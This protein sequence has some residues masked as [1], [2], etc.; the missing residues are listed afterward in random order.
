MNGLKVTG[1]INRQTSR[2]MSKPRCG[3]SDI[4]Q[5]HTPNGNRQKRDTS[6]TFETTLNGNKWKSRR[7]TW[8]L[9]QYSNKIYW[10]DQQNI[11]DKIF[12]MWSV[13]SPLQIHHTSNTPDIDISFARWIHGDGNYNAFDGKGRM[14][15][16]AYGPGYGPLAGDIH[17]DNDE[18]WATKKNL[19][20]EHAKDFFPIAL[21]EAGH[22]LGLPHSTSKHA[23]MYPIYKGFEPDLTLDVD[24]V[25]KLQ[26]I[27]GSNPNFVLRQTKKKE[28]FDEIEES[29]N[30]KP[31]I[32]RLNIKDVF[33]D[34]GYP[35]PTRRLLQKA[36]YNPQA[37][38]YLQEYNRLYIFK[39]YII[40]RYTNMKLDTGYP[41]KIDSIFPEP[42]VAAVNIYDR[43]GRSRVFLFGRKY[44][45]GWNYVTELITGSTMLINSFWRDFPDDIDA[46]VR[47]KDGM[48][49][50]FKGQKYYKV[51]EHSRTVLPGYPKYFGP[52]WIGGPCGT[53]D[54]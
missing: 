9:S 51:S 53:S 40:W 26:S 41:K 24:D 43:R 19:R 29:M 5:P 18:E 1:K 25:N 39:G 27:Y 48:I 23:V 10:Q 49:Y 12:S 11:L 42:P 37:V 16:H 13:P 45:W 38:V 33:Y 21:H 2:I 31:A 7:L 8:R 14:L 47:W 28:E 32:C 6:E 34:S 4:G 17:F 54:K 36:P 35:V 52:S 20:K 3:N 46:A 50:A 15:A 22:S 44:F 30:N